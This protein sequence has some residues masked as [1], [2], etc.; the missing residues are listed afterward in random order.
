MLTDWQG[1]Q[2]ASIPHHT[3]KI[4]TLHPQTPNVKQISP[5]RAG[6]IE[7]DFWEHP[8]SCSVAQGWVGHLG[9]AGGTP[10]F[11]RSGRSQQERAARQ[12]K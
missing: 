12:R 8:S 4:L 1:D 3:V 2:Q 7:E 5:P 9:L 11:Q 10:A 6:G